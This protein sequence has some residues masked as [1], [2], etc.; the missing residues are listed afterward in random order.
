MGATVGIALVATAC[1][2]VVVTLYWFA[3]P[4]H[5]FE[6][7]MAIDWEGLPSPPPQE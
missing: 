6:N 2:G 3:G 5:V 1:A 4:R 7:D